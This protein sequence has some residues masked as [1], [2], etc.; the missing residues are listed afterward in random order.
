M[1]AVIRRLARIVVV[2]CAADV[3]MRHVVCLDQAATVHS[4]RAWQAVHVALADYD[5]HTSS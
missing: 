3:F 4:E 5:E 2:E 1:N